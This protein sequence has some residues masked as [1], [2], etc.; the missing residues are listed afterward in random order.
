MSSSNTD[1]STL[2]QGIQALPVDAFD[3]Q[4]LDITAIEDEVLRFAGDLKSAASAL[5]QD[6]V[7]RKSTAEG[8]GRMA[9]WQKMGLVQ[10]PADAG[11]EVAR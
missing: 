11:E 4:G 5:R 1:L 6:L 3:I 2:M 10:D 9:R 8:F 7:K